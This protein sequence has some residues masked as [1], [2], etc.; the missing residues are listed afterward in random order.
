M[1]LLSD[2]EYNTR[3]HHIWYLANKEK[4]LSYIKEYRKTEKG[5]ESSKKASLKWRKNNKTKI[6]KV[7]AKEWRTKNRLKL[8]K[9]RRKWAKTENGRE[10][11]R[12]TNIKYRQTERGR[13]KVIELVKKYQLRNR[14]R[15]KAEAKARWKIKMQ[16]CSICGKY[17]SHRHHPEINK[18]L[19]VIFLCPLH[20]KQ[21]E[22][23]KLVL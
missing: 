7:K 6:N 14:K 5:K 3:R 17:P 23:G 9:Y 16:P 21:V 2:K 15:V 20:H 11:T 8:N 22:S 19:E 13:L 1:E 18:P 4:V 10:L 12:K